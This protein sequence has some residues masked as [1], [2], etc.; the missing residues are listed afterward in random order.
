MG[1]NADLPSVLAVLA[2]LETVLVSRGEKVPRGA[3]V[4]A[5][6]AD[7]SAASGADW[8]RRGTGR[9]PGR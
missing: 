4:D 9:A 3:A 2:A 7:W 5:A 8:L 1:T 6:L